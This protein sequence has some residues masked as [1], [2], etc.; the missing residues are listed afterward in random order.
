MFL[1]GT[2]ESFS[3][4]LLPVDTPHSPASAQSGRSGFKQAEVEVGA[5]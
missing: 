1:M 3:R 4:R 5:G 2:V